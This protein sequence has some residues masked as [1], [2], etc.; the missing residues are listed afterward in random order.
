MKRSNNRLSDPR[1]QYA[2]FRVGQRLTEAAAA[3]AAPAPTWTV[4]PDGTISGRFDGPDALV[5]LHAWI[6]AIPTAV[7]SSAR[8]PGGLEYTLVIAHGDDS[9][10]IFAHVPYTASARTAV[11][12]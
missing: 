1:A 3:T 4:E 2:A 5:A 10:T 6:R 9:V 12:V 8:R 7:V 11:S